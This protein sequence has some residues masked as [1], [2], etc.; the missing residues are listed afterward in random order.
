M[1]KPKVYYPVKLLLHFMW[2]R[3]NYKRRSAATSPMNLTI[4]DYGRMQPSAFH[5]IDFV[6]LMTQLTTPTS[7]YI[8]FAF[9]GCPLSTFHNRERERGTNVRP[10]ID[11]DANRIGWLDWLLQLGNYTESMYETSTVRVNK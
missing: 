7:V 5:T 6:F 11:T 3:S 8:V 10:E 1:L 9:V 4:G 2:R